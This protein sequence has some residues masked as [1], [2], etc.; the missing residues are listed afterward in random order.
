MGKLLMINLEIEGNLKEGLRKF[1]TLLGLY[2]TVE[3]IECT[4]GGHDAV[5]KSM[6]RLSDQG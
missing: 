5:T 6:H 2:V 1:R 4:E 3:R